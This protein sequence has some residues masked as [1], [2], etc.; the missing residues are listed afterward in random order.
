MGNSQQDKYELPKYEWVWAG[1]HN[2]LDIY[3]RESDGLQAEK[4]RIVLD[5]R[6][7]LE[8]E[9]QI[10]KLRENNNLG[11]VRVYQVDGVEDPK[12]QEKSNICKCAESTALNVY[13]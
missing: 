2:G 7:T 6:F 1:N 8:N 9:K 12:A 10:Y 13:S 3:K 11:F 4:R 5:P